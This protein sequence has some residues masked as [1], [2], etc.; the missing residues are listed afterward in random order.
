M[1]SVQLPEFIRNDQWPPDSPEPW[2][3]MSGARCWKPITSSIRNP[4]Q[5]P[6]SKS[7]TGELGQS[8]TATDQQGC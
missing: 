4:S 6:N 5:S 2:T 7:V 8:A 3:I 1:A